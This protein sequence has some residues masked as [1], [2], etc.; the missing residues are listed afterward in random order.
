MTRLLLKNIKN[1]NKTVE[2]DIFFIIRIK[3]MLFIVL[4]NNHLDYF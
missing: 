3:I 1:V 2:K 4:F